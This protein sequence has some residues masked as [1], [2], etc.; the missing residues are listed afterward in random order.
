MKIKVIIAD[1]NS[2]I[3]EGMKIILSTYDEFEVLATVED[4]LQ[5]VEFCRAQS[6]D[7]ALLDVRMPNMD[8]VEAARLI[9]ETGAKPFILTTFDDDEYIVAAIRNGAKGYLL[10]N[11]EPERIRDAIKSVFNGHI[12][13]QDIILDKIKSNLAEHK[14]AE[15]K[16]DEACLPNASS[17]LWR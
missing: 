8:G 15:P 7:I 11:A 5:A 6:V 17:G 9:S 12:V 16:I 13:M 3:R 4:G 2:F 1:D 10:K 14:E